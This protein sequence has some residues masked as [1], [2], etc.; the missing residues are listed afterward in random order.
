MGWKSGPYDRPQPYGNSCGANWFNPIVPKALKTSKP[1]LQDVTV[2]DFFHRSPPMVPLLMF[3]THSL[4]AHQ[5]H[6]ALFL[7]V[8]CLILGRCF[9]A[10]WMF[11]LLGWDAQG[12]CCWHKT[13]EFPLI[14]KFKSP[15][16]LSCWHGLSEIFYVIF[17]FLLIQTNCVKYILV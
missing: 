8:C 5:A 14:F 7:F 12:R 2:R 1:S 3:F 10:I 16:L 13:R 4:Q 15:C 11:T 17:G 9:S 6:Y